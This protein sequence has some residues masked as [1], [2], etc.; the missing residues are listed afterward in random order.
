MTLDT[1]DPVRVCVLFDGETTTEWAARA[2]ERMVAE[3]NAE[4]VLAVVD[5]RSDS[6]AIDLL[7]RVPEKP[8]WARIIGGRAVL[9]AVLGA[10]AYRR[11]R[12]IDEIEGL[13]NVPRIY[14]VPEPVDAFGVTLPDDVVERIGEQSDLVF[15]RGFGIIKGDVLTATKYGVLSYHHDD[16][17]EYRG[18]PPGFWEYMHGRET[19]G[20]M[21]QQLTEDLDGGRI[22]VYDEIDVSDAKTWREV[23]RRLCIHSI[24]FLTTAVERLQNESFEPE[25]IDPLG[26]IYTAP[27]WR[28]YVRYQYKNNVGRATLIARQILGG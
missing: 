10:P 15:R 16:P 23:H 26:P 12:P 11:D 24:G 3:T 21:L 13:E 14:C 6:S 5:D 22:V 18:G 28:E 25:P 7:R 19:A 8:H 9:D 20:L 2:I 27:D 4:I 1:E 17:T